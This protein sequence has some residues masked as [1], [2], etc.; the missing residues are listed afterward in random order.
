MS[1]SPQRRFEKMENVCDKRYPC[2]FCQKEL[3][4]LPRHLET[5]HSNERDVMMW[6]SCTNKSLKQQLYVKMKN[7]GAHIHNQAILREGSGNLKV[8]YR[9]QTDCSV[10][11]YIPCSQCYMCIY[12]NA[13]C[14][15]TQ[16][17]ALSKKKQTLRIKCA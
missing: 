10:A 5:A 3:A 1:K 12:A 7:Q 15:N 14:G 11:N 17:Y 4:K 9:P 6:V 16:R 8:K 2:L 13:T